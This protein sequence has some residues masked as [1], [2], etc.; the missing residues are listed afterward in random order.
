[1]FRNGSDIDD[2]VT[3]LR[4]I[5]AWGIDT[6]RSKTNVEYAPIYIKY[7]DLQE[8]DHLD[9]KLL[10]TWDFHPGRRSRIG[11]LGGFA[12]TTRQSG[13][14]DLEP[15]IIDPI[16]RKTKKTSFRVQPSYSLDLTQRLNLG[17]WASYRSER[18]ASESLVDS[19]RI[20]VALTANRKM[21]R[22]HV[23][24]GQLRAEAVDFHDGDPISTR[25]DRFVSAELSWQRVAG[26]L[27][28]WTA[29]AGI[30]RAEGERAPVVQ[31]P[32]ARFK[33]SWGLPVMKILF[34]YDLGYSTGG[35]LGATR[36]QSASAALHRRWGRSFETLIR[37][38]YILR[39]DLINDVSR[40][41][42]VNGY[43]YGLQLSYRWNNG[44]GVMLAHH[45][46]RQDREPDQLLDFGE[47][48]VGVRYAPR[49]PGGRIR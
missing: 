12:E 20:G 31:E 10:S 39:E 13:Y 16:V 9:H 18:Y 15:D 6:P 47:T 8:L 33:L 11:F 34:G 42:D 24:G 44:L 7:D 48:T 29:A 45:Q 43:S 26:G 2:F 19:D 3:R 27:L 22:G 41:G 35:G 37:G 36:R 5:T 25:F 40:R 38:H 49:S 32:S 30:F 46:I 23:F 21:D 17:A 4:V 28:N 14:R 1:V